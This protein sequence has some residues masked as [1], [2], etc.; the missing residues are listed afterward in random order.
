[1]KIVEVITDEG[2]VDTILGIAEQFDVT[3]Y[4]HYQLDRDDRHVVRMLVS[5]E[6]IQAVL[7]TT[8]KTIT[9]SERSRGVVMPVEATMP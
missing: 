9:A 7:D 4:W 1:M 5:N 3:D 2:H 6:L 8:Q